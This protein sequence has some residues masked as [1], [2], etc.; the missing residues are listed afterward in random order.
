MT[1]IEKFLLLLIIFTFILYVC[2]FGALVSSVVNGAEMYAPPGM[3]EL[4]DDAGLEVRGKN[5][6]R[7]TGFLHVRR[8]D[9][10]HVSNTYAVGNK[11]VVSE[12]TFVMMSPGVP[13]FGLFIY[14]RAYAGNARNYMRWLR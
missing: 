8:G 2:C 9:F 6:Y 13:A 5:F 10:A 7:V 3:E 14:S 12:Q 4:S 11:P 1:G